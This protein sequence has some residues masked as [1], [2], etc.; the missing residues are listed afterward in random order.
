M[1]PL[2]FSSPRLFPIPKG[3]G[4]TLGLGKQRFRRGAMRPNQGSRPLIWHF[5][6]V[7]LDLNCAH[8]KWVEARGKI[9][10]HTP[11]PTKT[12]EFEDGAWVR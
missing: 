11:K 10:R 8:G 1:L 5:S 12:R 6:L 9:S 3:M 7:N 4:F 2:G